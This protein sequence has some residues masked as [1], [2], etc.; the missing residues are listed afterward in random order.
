MTVLLVFTDSLFI[1]VQD[2]TY[3]HAGKGLSINS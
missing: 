1:P 3:M 2:A